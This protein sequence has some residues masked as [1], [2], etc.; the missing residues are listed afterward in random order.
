MAVIHATDSTARSLSMDDSNWNELA[1][2][3]DAMAEEESFSGVV[4]IRRNDTILL[5]RAFGYRDMANE[6]PNNTTT[7]FGI[8]SGTKLFT[9]LGIGVLI[10]QGLLSLETQVSEIESDNASYIDE[11]ATI[12]HLLSHTSG[13]YDYLDEEADIDFDNFFVDIPWYHLET[14][15]DYLPLFRGERPKFRAGERYSYSNG[16]F[17]YLGTIIEKR[18]GERYRDFL[19]EQ[20]LTKA[21]M[22]E[23]GFFALNEL[24]ANTANGYKEDRRTTNVFN[25]PIRGGG[26]GGMFTTAQDLHIF[27]QSFLSNRILSEELTAEF[28]STQHEFS[29]ETGYGCGVY[30]RLDDSVFSIAGGD[31]GVGFGSRYAPAER[32]TISV[33]SNVSD[34]EEQASKLIREFLRDQGE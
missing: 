8:A 33:L 6:I 24:P 2:R 31:A 21:G 17:V 18:S 11:S 10:D 22:T 1:S 34:G 9:A 19:S 27:W 26:D 29:N 23:S 13:I 32:R 25:L 16:G 20:V 30:K 4:S 14:P 12:K 15:S 3:I 5:E 7:K 28:L